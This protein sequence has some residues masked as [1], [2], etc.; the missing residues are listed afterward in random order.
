M[1]LFTF[2][3]NQGIPKTYSWVK[4]DGAGYF[5]NGHSKKF[6]AS[7]LENMA[8][9]VLRFEGSFLEIPGHVFCMFKDIK[10]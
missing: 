5:W 7:F 2:E 1:C 8:V 6:H 4:V 3:E 10:I 9:W